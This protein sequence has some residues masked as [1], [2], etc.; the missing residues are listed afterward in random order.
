MLCTTQL[1]VSPGQSPLGSVTPTHSGPQYQN[2]RDDWAVTVSIVYET[3]S[4]TVDNENAI[5]TGWRPGELSEAG[6]QQARLLGDRRRNDGIAVVYVSD[7]A[8]AV[9]TVR[10][11]FE[12]SDV[13]IRI[14]TRLRECNYGRFDGAPV[15]TLAPER[16]GHID[17]PWPE[18]ESYRDV[19]AR[20][21]SLLDDIRSE[22]DG[23]R[24]LL[25]GHSANRWALQ[26]L[27]EGRDLA[28][29]VVAPFDWQPGWEF[30]L[31]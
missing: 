9:D 27:I 2:A 23:Q 25:V 3:H 14:D 28:E 6:L 15:A 17:R 11:A 8:R 30:E 5:A 22:W 29:L 10:I 1:P 20:T 13:P 4:T 19:V 18:G 31:N 24:V 16:T 21:R 26:H 12:G 7:L